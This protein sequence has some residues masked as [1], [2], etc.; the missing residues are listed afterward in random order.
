VVLLLQVEPVSPVSSVSEVSDPA[1][2]AIKREG[3]VDDNAFS[4]T[5]LTRLTGRRTPGEGA[6]LV[7]GSPLGQ[8]GNFPAVRLSLAASLSIGIMARRIASIS[9]G[10]G[11]P[12]HPPAAPSPHAGFISLGG[13]PPHDRACGYAQIF[14]PP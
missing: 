9:L 7:A 2:Q 14:F 6:D 8:R 1:L 12:D 11:A 5:S 3:L 10:V 4:L 13:N